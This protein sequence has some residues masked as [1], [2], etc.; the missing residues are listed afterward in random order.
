MARIVHVYFWS[1]DGD[2]DG[3]A[4]ELTDIYLFSYLHIK[5]IKRCYICK[6]FVYLSV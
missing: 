4:T 6:Y 3:T 2:W 5:N 1:T